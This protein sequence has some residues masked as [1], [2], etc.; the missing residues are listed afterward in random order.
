MPSTD[1]IK[2]TVDV[3]TLLKATDKNDQNEILKCFTS[4]NDAN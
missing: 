1:A 3:E 4:N 2:F